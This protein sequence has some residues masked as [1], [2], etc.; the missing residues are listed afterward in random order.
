VFGS[1][2]DI[3]GGA[4]FLRRGER[5]REKFM[6]DDHFTVDGTLI[7]AWA[8]QKSFRPKDGLDSNPRSGDGTNFHG[9]E[10]SNEKH[11]STTDPDARL[12]KKSYGK[13]SHLCRRHH[14]PAT[15]SAPDLPWYRLIE[16]Q[17]CGDSFSVAICLRVYRGSHQ[18]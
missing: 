14:E 4:A 12:Y 8:S 3:R 16:S 13:E 1:G 18:A 10:R 6:S 5:T 11:E 9:Q 2:A 17:P 15:R 7:Q